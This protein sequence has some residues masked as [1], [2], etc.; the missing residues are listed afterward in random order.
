VSPAPGTTILI[1]EL[2]CAEAG[3]PPVETAI[4][5]LAEGKSTVV[6]VHKPIV[7]VR[8]ADVVAALD[9]HDHG[10]QLAR[11][12]IMPDCVIDRLDGADDR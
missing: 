2:V 10:A 11:R 8:R 9:G 12:V 7:D 6:T 3:C 4:G 1:T 5:I